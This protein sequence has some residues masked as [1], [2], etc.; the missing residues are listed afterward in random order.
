MFFYHL[1]V[2]AELWTLSLQLCYFIFDWDFANKHIVFLTRIK[3]F[4]AECDIVNIFL[5]ILLLLLA[6]SQLI[7]RVVSLTVVFLTQKRIKR[8]AFP[9]NICVFTLSVM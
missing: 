9:R 4:I 6:V 7:F 1:N 8:G 2:K 5:Q 3:R